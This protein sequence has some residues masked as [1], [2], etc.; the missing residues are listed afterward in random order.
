MDKRKANNNFKSTHYSL[1]K[2]EMD[3]RK[4]NN[5]FKPTHYFSDSDS[6][7]RSHSDSNSDSGYNSDSNY[8]KSKNNGFLKFMY[9]LIETKKYIKNDNS[10]LKDGPLMNKIV[11]QYLFKETKSIDIAIQKY[12][13][14]KEVFRNKLEEAHNELYEK[15]NIEEIIE[16]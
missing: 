2:K 4:A 12:N 6:R 7:F 10:T 16:I 5:N 13:N 3:K 11:S 1:N 9:D 14:N 8:N 15:R